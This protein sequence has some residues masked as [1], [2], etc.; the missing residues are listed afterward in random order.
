MVLNVSEAR[1]RDHPYFTALANEIKTGGRE[2]LLD[3]LMSI[4]LDGWN[5]RAVPRSDALH[6]QQVETSKRSDPVAAWWLERCPRESL[7]SRAGQWRGHLKS[8]QPTCSRVTAWRLGG[9]GTH[10]RTMSRRRNAQASCPRARS[11]KFA[12][13]RMLTASS[14]IGCPTLARRGALQRCHRGGPMRDLTAVTPVA[15]RQVWCDGANAR[16]CWARHTSHT[17]HPIFRDRTKSNYTHTPPCH[18]GRGRTMHVWRELIEFA[19]PGVAGVTRPANPGVS[20]ATRLSRR[21]PITC[22]AARKTSAEA[23]H[24]RRL[25]SD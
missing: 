9:P 17:S 14:T 24:H 13:H 25:A 2:A 10:R 19:V 12:S 1:M 4:N 15:P 22:D 3:Y 6:T 7:P 23:N 18:R 11:P 5:P 21:H 20:A 16:I 8:R